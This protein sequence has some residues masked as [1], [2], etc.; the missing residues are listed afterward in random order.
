MQLEQ[1][2]RLPIVGV[3]GSGTEAHSEKAKPLGEWL[4]RQGVHLL[5]GGG[6]GVMESVSRAFF[7]VRERKGFVIGIIPG[8]ERDGRCE[9]K[10]GYPNRWVEIPIFTHLPLS[11]TRGADPMSRN[12]IN[13]LSSDVLVALPGAA[14]TA[15][16]VQLALTYDKPFVVFCDRREDIAGLPHDV[17]SEPDF[18]KVKSFVLTSI[19]NED[20]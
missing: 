18:E 12:H 16:E 20:R 14:G 2:K 3:I 10:P 1:S 11:G 19:G 13:I 4:A 5:T 7:E 6:G 15:S 8:A 17:P 9:P